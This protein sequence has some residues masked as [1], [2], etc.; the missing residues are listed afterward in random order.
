[1]PGTPQ[2]PKWA[3]ATITKQTQ[4]IAKTK[5]TKTS[6]NQI[7]SFSH[8]F[9]PRPY[10]NWKNIRNQLKPCSTRG[11]LRGHL[12]KDTMLTLLDP[13]WLCLRF[14]PQLCKKVGRLCAAA[15]EYLRLA[16]NRLYRYQFDGNYSKF[17]YISVSS[18]S[19]SFF[20]LKNR[21]VTLIQSTDSFTSTLFSPFL[22]S[23]FFLPV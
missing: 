10:R 18:W 20:E 6:D 9:P 17:P 4:K 12:F 1:M 8:S 15:Y 23:M 7:F 19:N 22:L 21:N 3:S 16:R 11:L 14:V 2:K 13:I 5:N